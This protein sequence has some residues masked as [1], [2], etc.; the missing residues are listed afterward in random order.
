MFLHT[1][2]E[3]IVK[4]ESCRLVQGFTRDYGGDGAGCVEV[5]HIIVNDNVAGTYRTRYRASDVIEEIA[6]AIQQGD[7]L[8]T[9][10]K[11]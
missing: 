3:D 11:W 1:Q 6:Q 5:F 4:L 7:E 9:M 10:P 8:Y 2:K